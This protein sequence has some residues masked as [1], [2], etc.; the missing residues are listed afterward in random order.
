MK[1]WYRPA[2]RE[3]NTPLGQPPL[4]FIVTASEKRSFLEENNALL[5]EQTVLEEASCPLKQHHANASTKYTGRHA[6]KI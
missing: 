4:Q 1:T 2:L 6:I 3:M 5:L